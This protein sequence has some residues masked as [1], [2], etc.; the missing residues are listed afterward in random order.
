MLWFLFFHAG[1]ERPGPGS[2]AVL[3]GNHSDI[4]YE[5]GSVSWLTASTIKEL[6]HGARWDTS[7]GQA[8]ANMDYESV[9]IS[10]RPCDCPG[11]ATSA[12]A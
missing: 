9:L 10:G 2:E 11:C 4:G 6:G 1:Q 8:V 3:D 5:N 7:H 12:D